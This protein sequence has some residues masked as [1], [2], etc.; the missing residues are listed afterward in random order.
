MDEVVGAAAGFVGEV[1]AGDLE[2]VE[3]ETSAAGV[4]GVGGELVHD[5]ADGELDGGVVLGQG[6]GEGG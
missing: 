5:G 1:A 3:E 4:E 6:D 2:G